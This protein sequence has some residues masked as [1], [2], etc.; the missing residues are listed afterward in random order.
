MNQ[1][2]FSRNNV[3]TKK[4]DKTQVKVD[5]YIKITDVLRVQRMPN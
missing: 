1:I 4:K 3:G 2:G 5:I